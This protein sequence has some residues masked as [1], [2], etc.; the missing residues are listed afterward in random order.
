MISKTSPRRESVQAMGYAVG[1]DFG[2]T[3]SAIG[4]VTADANGQRSIHHIY[5]YSDSFY[6][7]SCVYVQDSQDRTFLIGRTAINEFLETGNTECF[8]TQFKLDLA[9]EYPGDRYDRIGVSPSILAARVIHR[10]LR[11]ADD[12]GSGVLA[13]GG[14]IK[15]ATLTV[16]AGWSEVQK[17]QTIEA[18]RAAGLERITLLKEPTAALYFINR[19]Q[20]LA[21]EKDKNLMVVDYGGG[22]CDVTICRTGMRSILLEEPRIL[23][24]RTLADGVG[25]REIDRAL[26]ELF[27]T[28]AISKWRVER[29]AVEPFRR[30]LEVLAEQKKEDYV[31]WFT[32]RRLDGEKPIKVRMDGW[33]KFTPF[34]SELLPEDFDRVVNPIVSR[35]EIPIREALREA[36]LKEQN[37]HQVYLVGGSSLVPAARSKV[38]EIFGKQPQFSP[39]ARSAVC[40]GAALWQN[41]KLTGEFPGGQFRPRRY[42]TLCMVHRAKPNLILR[43]I[44]G[45]SSNNPKLTETVLI[46]SGSMLPCTPRTMEFLTAEDNLTYVEITI[47]ERDI[48]GT[49]KDHEEIYAKTVLYFARPISRNSIIKVTYEVDLEDRLIL[50]AELASS[51]QKAI[52]EGKRSINEARIAEIRQRAMLP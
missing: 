51:G 50:S 47:V 12:P 5:I 14:Q 32:R 40:S 31:E 17:T 22:T 27:L 8:F 33:S 10:L 28:W 42:S 52:I 46:K 26:S 38:Q 37:I 45:R 1:I 9:R 3:K 44:S 20:G 25:G 43:I 41:Y 34:E 49:S 24:E 6:L 2:T 19:D 30:H 23:S 21:E 36:G 18:A 35:I 16:P 39:S 4:Y 29:N 11:I 15:S 48:E 7:P 13:A